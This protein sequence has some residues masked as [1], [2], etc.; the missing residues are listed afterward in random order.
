M[1]CYCAFIMQ[2]Y[3]VLFQVSSNAYCQLLFEVSVSKFGKE[4]SPEERN[5]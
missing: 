3:F 4:K 5:E 1:C 2:G